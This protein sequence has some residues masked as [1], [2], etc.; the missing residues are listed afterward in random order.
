[1]KSILTAFLLGKTQVRHKLIDRLKQLKNNFEKSQFFK[2]HEVIGSSLLIIHNGKEVEVR[3][4]DFA[5]TVPLPEG[6]EIDHKSPW[7]L[8]NHE[9]GYLF[10]LQNLIN[11][12]EQ[13]Y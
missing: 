9:D 12:L 8:G 10:G 4:I 1:V 5:K 3:M 7:N 2:T 13:S 11:I 6:I